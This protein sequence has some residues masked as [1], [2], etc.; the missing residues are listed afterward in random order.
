[1]SAWNDMLSENSS[2]STETLQII[3]GDEDVAES[4]AQGAARA[5][6]RSG[7][8][9]SEEEIPPTFLIARA[10]LI[11]MQQPNIFNTAKSLWGAVLPPISTIKTFMSDKESMYEQYE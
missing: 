8:H 2:S 9:D 6:A 10:V 3:T 4:S 1:M 7:Q 11:D 5:L